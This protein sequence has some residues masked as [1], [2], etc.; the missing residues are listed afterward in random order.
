MTE[1]TIDL[2]PLQPKQREFSDTFVKFRLYGGAKGGGKSYSMRSECVRQ[3]LSAPGV[4]GLALRRTMPE[5]QENMVTPMMLEIPNSI[6]SYNAQNHIMTFFNGSTLRFSYCRNTKDV[7]NFQGIEYDFIAIEELTHWKESEFRILSGSLRTTKKGIIPNFFGSTN[8]GGIGHGWVKRIFI[9]RDFREG[10]HPEDYAFIPAKVWDNEILMQ[11]Q[12][13]YLKTLQALPEE[14]RRAFLE[15]DW[16]VFKGQY[17]KEFRREYHVCSPF[18][19]KKEDGV[20]KRI[21]AFDYGYA[22]PSCVLWGAQYA[23]GRVVIYREL[24]VT[25]HTYSQ[26]AKKIIDMTPEMKEINAVIC[27]PAIVEKRNEATSSTGKQEMAKCGLHIIGGDNRRVDGWHN[28]RKYL[29]LY[30]TPA[31]ETISLLQITENCENLIRTLPQ[32]IHDSRNVEDMDTTVEDHPSDSLRYLLKFLGINTGGMVG[33]SNQSKKIIENIE[34]TVHNASVK[35]NE[36]RKGKNM[37]R[38]RW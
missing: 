17:F 21:I 4:R 33:V 7:L 8:P 13:D 34:K 3:C 32:M 9:D 1:K 5:I 16:D 28:V 36:R 20:T 26:L 29:Q 11:R 19:P 18:Y 31:G 14:E 38:E 25:E 35:L 37:L 24:Y 2:Y 10:E 12:P 27:D 6:Y 23:S 22:A 30:E 15:G